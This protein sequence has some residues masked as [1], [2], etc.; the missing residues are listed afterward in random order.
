MTKPITITAGKWR[1]RGG[2]IATIKG[3]QAGCWCIY[4]HIGSTPSEWRED[5]SWSIQ[6]GVAYL[7]DLV[8]RIP[9]K[10]PRPAAK[11]GKAQW[12]VVIGIPLDTKADALKVASKVKGYHATVRR[13]GS[14]KK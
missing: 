10:K 12:L 2:R 11:R 6:P 13:S 5:G 1:M 8:S 7:Y 3:R 9:D 4:G 14:V